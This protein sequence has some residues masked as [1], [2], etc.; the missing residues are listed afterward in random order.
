MHRQINDY[1]LDIEKAFSGDIKP[2]DMVLP[3][4]L[5]G[6]VGSLVAPGS[7]GKGYLA[8]SICASLTTV[9]LLG[10]G[11]QPTDCHV[12]YITAEDPI[13]VLEHRID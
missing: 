1:L 4:L 12:A 8:N 5:A 7:T 6:S 2:L 13:S 9:D 10:F 3:G 11:I